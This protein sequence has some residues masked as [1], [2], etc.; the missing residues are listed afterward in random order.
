M[1]ARHR[2]QK[3]SDL[4]VGIDEG[5]ASSLRLENAGEHN[6]GLRVSQCDMA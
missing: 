1:Q 2:A 5:S 3:I 4:L 6:L